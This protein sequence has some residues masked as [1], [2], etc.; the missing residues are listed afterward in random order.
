MK[1]DALQGQALGT[2]MALVFLVRH[3]MKT[4]LPSVLLK[5]S[6]LFP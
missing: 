2:S 5:A 3:V 1:E 6:L 4:C